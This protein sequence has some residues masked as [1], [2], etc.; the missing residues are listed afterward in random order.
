M[1][2]DNNLAKK[3]QAL[4]D[5][6]LDTVKQLGNLLDQKAKKEKELADLAESIDKAIAQ[7]VDA[8]WKPDEL[9][10]LGIPKPGKRRASKPVASAATPPPPPAAP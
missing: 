8:G 5:A 4:L 3:A 6:R 10:Q 1:A 9:A 2:D 7:C